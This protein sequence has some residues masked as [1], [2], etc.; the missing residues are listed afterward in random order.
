MKLSDDIK[1]KIKDEF[2]H[3]IEIQYA[4]KNKEERQKFGQFFT[5]PELTIKMI[6]KFSDL[7]GNVL[8][9]TVGCGGL[10]AACIISGANPRKCYGIEL[11]KDIAIICRD[12]LAKLGVPRINIK[13]GDAL[14]DE[15]YNFDDKFENKS[16]MYLKIE[17]LGFSTVNVMIEI[18][19][20]DGIL[21]VKKWKIEL[22]NDDETLKKKFEQIYKVI[23]I[24]NY[25]E[26]DVYLYGEK[27]K[28]RLKFLKVF[29]KKYL[30]ITF[31]V[32]NDKIINLE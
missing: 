6:E 25:K 24:V 1:N 31:K 28:N 23:N 26:K 29:F 9:P 17:D 2:N 13:I 12:R 27:I 19:K 22:S 11:D 16:L 21:V 10:L 30:D 3:W 8:D 18:N 5:P 4:G 32:N 15:S 14:K 20:K 7:N